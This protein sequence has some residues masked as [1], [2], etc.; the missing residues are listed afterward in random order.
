MRS[1][2][3]TIWPRA[4]W[5]AVEWS[6]NVPELLNGALHIAISRGSDSEDERIITWEGDERFADLGI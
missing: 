4:A 2:G 3:R 1:A 6:E 5:C